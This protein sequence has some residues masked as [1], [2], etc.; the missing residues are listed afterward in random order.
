MVVRIVA[1][2]CAEAYSAVRGTLLRLEDEVAG[3]SSFTSTDKSV[4]ATSI[5][6]FL[7]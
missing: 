2:I 1:V 7:A 3:I 5:L 4:C 6:V